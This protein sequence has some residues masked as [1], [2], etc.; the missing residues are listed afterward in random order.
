LGKSSVSAA[1]RG[2]GPLRRTANDSRNVST[3]AGT[4]ARSAGS[5]VARSAAAS[6]SLAWPSTAAHRSGSSPQA[7]SGPD[8]AP[9]AYSMVGS[10]R[11]SAWTTVGSLAPKRD[12]PDPQGQ[13]FGERSGRDGR[14][15]RRLPDRHD[16]RPDRPRS[17]RGEQHAQVLDG[18]D[19]GVRVVGRRRGRLAG[20]IDQLPKVQARI[21]L[22]GPLE[23]DPHRGVE[24][25]REGH[26]GRTHDLRRDGP[27]P[28]QG[29]TR[30]DVLPHPRRDR[31]F[32]RR[33][34]AAASSCLG[35][36]LY[37]R[38]R[39]RTAWRSVDADRLGDETSPRSNVRPSP[40]PMITTQIGWT[41][42]PT[43][44]GV[45]TT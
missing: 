35:T 3:S 15:S 2:A 31:T 28:G 27:D 42:A 44:C 34:A 41:L 30:G 20:R 23:P 45:T 19:R 13:V 1:S 36:G 7:Y 38:V 43:G 21:L 5:T 9:Q 22:Q 24:I 26:H 18:L 37:R 32:T 10:S 11:S 6:S 8:R 4:G 25:G 14:P 33:A 12:Q 16:Q 40:A 17:Q 39:Q 29:R